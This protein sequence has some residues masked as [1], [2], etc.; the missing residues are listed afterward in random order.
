MFAVL[1]GLN[2]ATM[3]LVIAV[4]HLRSGIREHG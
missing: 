1:A 3:P 4:F 2:L